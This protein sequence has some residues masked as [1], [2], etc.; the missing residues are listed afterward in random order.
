ML[1]VCGHTFC[2]RCIRDYLDAKGPVL[3][4]C[5]SCREKVTPDELVLNV[6][7]R[8]VTAQYRA[9]C[10]ALS[11]AA[12][13]AAVAVPAAA[14]SASAAGG[15]KRRRSTGGDDAG[16]DSDFEDPPSSQGRRAAVGRA[17]AAAVD[18]RARH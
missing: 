4:D 2:A 8:E 13:V 6:K 15:T 3:G 1:K 11:A 10:T 9:L 7:L 16:S 5:P 12:P 14:A 17:A 18:L